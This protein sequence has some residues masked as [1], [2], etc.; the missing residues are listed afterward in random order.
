MSEPAP[1]GTGPMLP[2]VEI[3]SF[4]GPLD[5]L[6][7]LIRKNE[8]AITDIPIAE[9][10]EQYTAYLDLMREI[11]LD[12]AA[13]YIY[14]AAVLIHI[15]SRSLLPR[16]ANDPDDD[17]RQDLVARLLEYEKFKRAAEGFHEIDTER[18]GLW[19]RP[20]AAPP[21]ADPDAPPPTLEVSLADLV[22]TFRIVLDRYRYA[23][24]AAI[25]V[26][27]PRFSLREKMIELVTR[28]EERGTLPLLELLGT[29]RYRTEAIT[30][31][32]AALELT[33][34]AVLRI[35][36]PAP[37]SEIHVSRT[38]RDFDISEIQDVYHD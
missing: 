21:S 22:G 17:P 37:F 23:H 28:V 38:D 19:P 4:S 11:D 30:T 7:H 9:I 27:H 8:V 36:Q 24:P 34:I 33:R 6:L 25:E 15:K 13:E 3:D 35:F 32:L 12:V 20:E 16:D 14:L 2:P 5:L 26:H 18:A 29:F 1:H 10:T 31:F